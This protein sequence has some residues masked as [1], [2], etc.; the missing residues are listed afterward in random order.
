[1]Y[2]VIRMHTINYLYI[3]TAALCADMQVLP[4]IC[5]PYMHYNHTISYVYDTW[6]RCHWR[7]TAV[8][9]LKS[10]TV[11][12]SRYWQGWWMTIE[13]MWNVVP[14]RSLRAV[15]I[16][17]CNVSYWYLKLCVGDSTS[18]SG[19]A[20]FWFWFLRSIISVALVSC[21]SENERHCST[22]PT[23]P[24]TTTPSSVEHQLRVQVNMGCPTPSHLTPSPTQDL[25]QNV[26]FAPGR[27]WRHRLIHVYCIHTRAVCK[28]K[29]KSRSGSGSRAKC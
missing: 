21:T 7:P 17:F 4:C 19:H 13:K 15:K 25:S 16:W 26:G 2:H 20:F 1:M 9:M 8:S 11:W 5:V 12:K 10:P 6:L 27:Q 22:T 3:Y 24:H 23:P 18:A 14:C 29:W 28:M